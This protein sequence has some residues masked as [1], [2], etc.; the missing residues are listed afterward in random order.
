LDGEFNRIIFVPVIALQNP[1]GV[2]V[3]AAGARV[4]VKDDQL[5]TGIGVAMGLSIEN[6]R[7]REELRAGQ[8]R[9]ERV[10]TGA[11]LVLFA[12]DRDGA[13][14]LVEGRGLE[15]LG[16]RPEEVLGR[17]IFDVFNGRTEI[18]DAVKRALAGEEVIA[19]A[20]F[21]GAT[22]E[23]RLTP[24]RDAAGQ[25]SGIVGVATDVSERRLAEEALRASEERL[26]TMVSNVPVVLFAIDRDGVFTL[27][28]GKGTC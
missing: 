2:I 20:D 16:T 3:L 24:V 9:L 6:L 21:S 11:P 19:S 10:V 5:L 12:L 18:T 22:F 7:Q 27:S 17:S 4:D 15:V 26:S 28:E 23:A 14:T 8:E 25:V 13:Y 1:I